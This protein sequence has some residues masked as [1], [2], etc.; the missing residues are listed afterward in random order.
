MLKT[1]I[2]ALSLFLVC[3]AGAHAQSCPLPNFVRIV[4]ASRLPCAPGASTTPPSVSAGVATKATPLAPIAGSADPVT[5]QFT[6]DRVTVSWSCPPD[7]AGGPVVS[8]SLAANLAYFQLPATTKVMLESMATVPA[9]TVLPLW[10]P[11]AEGMAAGF[12]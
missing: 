5:Y 2:Q 4:A 1:N 9:S 10:C 6:P 11:F 12:K 7:V 3:V 8:N